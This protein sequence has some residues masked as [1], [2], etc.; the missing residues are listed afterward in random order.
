MTVLTSP[1]PRTANRD[2]TIHAALFA[3]RRSILSDMAADETSFIS[4]S[5][6]RFYFTGT[7]RHCTGRA[8]M[9]PIS[10]DS[11]F[12]DPHCT[13]IAGL[14]VENLRDTEKAAT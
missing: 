13:S 5:R 9:C 2:I 6:L 10:K 8:D 1:I 3:I 4:M 7:T 12:A 11:I 14:S